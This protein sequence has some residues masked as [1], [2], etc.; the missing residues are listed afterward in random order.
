[1]SQVT[2]ENK[3]D[4]PYGLAAFSSK[5]AKI[6]DARKNEFDTSP[7][8]VFRDK[9]RQQAA[10]NGDYHWPSIF[11]DIDNDDDALLTSSKNVRKSSDD[12]LSQNAVTLSPGVDA[13]SLINYSPTVAYD[14]HKRSDGFRA[15]NTQIASQPHRFLYQD[16]GFRPSPVHATNAWRCP[17]SS[18]TEK[19]PDVTSSVGFQTMNYASHISSSTALPFDNGDFCLRSPAANIGGGGKSSFGATLIN[20]DVPD[21]N[22]LVN[23]LAMLNLQNRMR[24]GFFVDDKP[25]TSTFDPKLYN[26]VPT[27]QNSSAALGPSAINPA[28]FDQPTVNINCSRSMNINGPIG[29][30]RFGHQFFCSIVN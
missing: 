14:H 8:N 11:P 9:L 16:N 25:V 12:Q 5:A 6:A 20:G 24:D 22:A 26:T 2:V 27:V 29:R 18:S 3:V 7:G 10:V 13:Q 17:A 23:R 4:D 15:N 21:A 30:C 28:S 1:M 19:Q